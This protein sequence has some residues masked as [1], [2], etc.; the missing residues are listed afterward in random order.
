M[1]RALI[2][3]ESLPFCPTPFARCPSACKKPNM[4]AYS[5]TLRSMNPW[6]LG[7]QSAMRKLSPSLLV[8]PSARV[9]AL[10]RAVDVRLC[11]EARSS[12][13]WLFG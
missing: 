12:V 1:S 9:A 11:C 13:Q 8:R 2:S 3:T 4:Y 5:G 6:A 7:S 10:P